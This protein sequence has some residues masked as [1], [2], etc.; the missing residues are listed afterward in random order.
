MAVLGV[1]R[2]QHR[3]D[4]VLT[5]EQVSLVGHG[6]Q[7]PTSHHPVEG[8]QPAACRRGAMALATAV[9]AAVMA[10]S[11][12]PAPDE[13]HMAAAMRLSVMTTKARFD[14]S[15]HVISTTAMTRRWAVYI[16]RDIDPK[17][18]QAPARVPR[19]RPS[20]TRRSPSARPHV[21]S[22]LDNVGMTTPT[23]AHPP[24]AV[25]GTPRQRTAQGARRTQAPWC[26]SPRTASDR[27]SSRLQVNAPQG[28]T[29]TST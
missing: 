4:E 14:G 6:T 23:Q 21:A 15:R 27:A 2:L 25:S 7:H 3:R 18:A 20:G 11:S 12:G 28:R 5:W 19:A 8:L 9:D 26:Q 22:H 17:T 29:T 24:L 13:A 16:V 1:E 10:R